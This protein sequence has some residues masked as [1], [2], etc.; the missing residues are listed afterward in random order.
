MHSGREL[1]SE[2]DH[3]LEV[4]KRRPREGDSAQPDVLGQE[5]PGP[6]AGEQPPAEERPQE[7][8][9]LGSLPSFARFVL[10]EG[11]AGRGWCEPEA[12][13]AGRAGPRAVLH[14]PEQR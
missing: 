13:A 7:R 11:R 6:E 9:G 8:P 4:G 3:Y 10:T 12:E 5:G 14:A 1:D 2:L